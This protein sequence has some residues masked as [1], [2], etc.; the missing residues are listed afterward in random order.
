MM[1]LSPRGAVSYALVAVL[2]ARAGPWKNRKEP[3]KR[4]SS[5][6]GSG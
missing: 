6:R 4:D 1:H 2:A 5:S 3:P